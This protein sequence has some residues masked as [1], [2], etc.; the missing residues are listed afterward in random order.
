MTLDA[1]SSP[2]HHERVLHR[3]VMAPQAVAADDLPG[4]GRSADGG[5]I[6]PQDFMVEVVQS[7]FRFIGDL[8]GDVAVGEVA[9]DTAKLLVL[10][11]LPRRAHFLH[12]VAGQAKD[13]ASCSVVTLD[14]DQGDEDT[15][16][17]AR[18]EDFNDRPQSFV[19]AAHVSC[20]PCS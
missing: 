12:A 18:K 5:R 9:F 20:P 17:C 8:Y 19:F 14:G 16:E 15:C 6:C 4:F 2:L 11:L 1:I 10:R 7:G 13:R 3:R